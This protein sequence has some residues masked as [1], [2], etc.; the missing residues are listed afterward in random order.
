MMPLPVQFAADHAHLT[1]AE[2]AIARSVYYSALFDYPVRLSELRRTLIASAQT[3]T[4]ILNTIARSTSLPALVEQRDGFFFPTGR[5]DLIDIRQHREARSRA[6]LADHRPLLQL[7]ALL[8]Y[9]SFV[10]LSGSIAHLNLE[11]GGDLDLFIVTRGRRVWTAAVAIVLLAKLMRRRRTL[12]ANYIVADSAIAFDQQDLFT[13]SQIVNLKPVAGGR[14]FASILEANPFV[15][16]FYPNFHAPDTGDLPVQVPA[17]VRLSKPLVEWALRWPS[18]A[19]EMVCRTAYRR[20]LRRQSAR[21]TSPDQVVLGDD[22]LKLHTRS[23]RSTVMSRFDE[24]LR[25][26]RI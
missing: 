10:A 16:R 24:A 17:L 14:L 22:V 26:Q 8:P 19:L 11:A 18:A 13:A 15:R 23:H 7:I 20:Y 5:S 3:P 25:E 1:P 9:V 2:E 12:C 6:F 4:A 21:W